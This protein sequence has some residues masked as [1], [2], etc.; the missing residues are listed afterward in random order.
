MCPHSTQHQKSRLKY[1][2]TV[3]G[4]VTLTM[5]DRDL[6]K[7][8]FCAA[9]LALKLS[10]RR[11]KAQRVTL[12][13]VL[14]ETQSLLNKEGHT[15]PRDMFEVSRELQAIREQLKKSLVFHTTLTPFPG[16]P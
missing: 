10:P 7:K 1:C 14:D 11:E 8:L 6:L 16:Q 9:K 4:R 2:G 5:I 13:Q 15:I 3:T 12:C